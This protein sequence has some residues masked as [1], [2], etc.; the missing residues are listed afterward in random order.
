MEKFI[1]NNFDKSNARKLTTSSDSQTDKVRQCIAMIDRTFDAKFV[2]LKWSEM[3]KKLVELTT[4]GQQV[5]N[6]AV[7][8]DNSR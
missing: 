8:N 5:N 3:A 6:L 2:F 1:Y 4:A 7:K